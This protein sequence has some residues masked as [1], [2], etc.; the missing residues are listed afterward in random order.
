MQVM[1]HLIKESVFIVGRVSSVEGRK[2]K[3]RV[4]KNKN[5]SHISYKGKVIKNISVGSYIMICKG[6]IRII[7]RIEGEYVEEDRNY[8]S[9]YSKEEIK[10]NRFLEISLF[11]HFEGDEF[12]QGIKEMPLI[13]NECYLLSEED[14]NNLHKFYGKKDITIPIGHLTENSFH[15]LQLSVNKI[16][17]GHLGIFGNT[18]S[19]KSNTLA[20]IYYEL[21]N[22]HEKGLKIN[23]RFIFF[24]FNG[25]YSNPDIF[26]CA[27]TVYELS[28]EVKEVNTQIS[29]I[30]CKYPLAFSKSAEIIS[31]LLEAT[32][33]TQKPFLI[34][35]LNDKFFD[36][37]FQVNSKINIKKFL[38]DV[39]Q[40]T[41]NN[42]AF[43]L[44]YLRYIRD[45]FIVEED[46]STNI[47]K[48]IIN[49]IENGELM[50]N[51][52]LDC[53][54]SEPNGKTIYSNSGSN[55]LYNYFFKD[56]ENIK[57]NDSNFIETK[58]KIFSR[59]YHEIINNHSSPE[60]I[61]PLLV[62]MFR[63]FPVLEKVI[64]NV[65]PE[66]NIDSC[67]NVNY[68]DNIKPI[69]EIINLKNVDLEMK[70]SLPLMISRELYDN[71]KGGEFSKKS[72]H[73]I[74]DEAHNILSQASKRESES[75]KDYRLETF[76]EIIKEGRKFSV[77]M[78]IASQRPQ[79]ISMT[80]ISQLHNYF[81]HRL[82]NY[83]DI[84][85]LKNA[86]A[87]LDKLSFESI[88]LLP[89]GS[90]FVSGLASDIPV[91]INIDAVPYKNQP[92]SH[93][94]KLNKIWAIKKP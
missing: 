3:V 54:Y 78:T 18:G 23:S 51:S 72:L 55:D 87:Y 6:F 31:A 53:Y 17:T 14:F 79:D 37:H 75:W 43:I 66:K 36:N 83:D 12:K 48:T 91:K 63:R 80:I 19:G 69:I 50:Y 4:N 47:I 85:S 86:V 24:D 34:R 71:Q 93:N 61:G 15:K 76:E 11:G 58:F 20:K 21:F 32:E 52:T 74:I 49:K 28:T 39:L 73:I 9:K 13:D 57:I 90:C 92:K 25:E 62:R 26:P 59:Y 89:V 10:I 41:V 2:V 82:I 40:K 77:F 1:Q 67:E 30:K 29:G 7:G 8:Q 46:N 88:P 35:A 16:F 60:H 56:I 33:K 42:I 81:I 22:Q 5:L 84:Q 38:T 68:E 27:A 65:T 70:K 94:I 44:E 64:S 45:Q